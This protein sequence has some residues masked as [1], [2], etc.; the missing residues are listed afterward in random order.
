MRASRRHEA[1]EGGTGEAEGRTV[2]K[3]APRGAVRREIA[4]R[5]EAVLGLRSAYASRVPPPG[6]LRGGG[7]RNRLLG[8]RS[9]YASRGPP[10]VLCLYFVRQ[11]FSLTTHR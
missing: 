1:T 5:S 10:P 7:T 4:G 9:A 3:G 6:A 11:G 8:L 2:C